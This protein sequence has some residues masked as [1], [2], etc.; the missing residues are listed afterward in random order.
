MRKS[1]FSFLFLAA[2][3]VFALL[4]PGAAQAPEPSARKPLSRSAERWVQQTLKKMT[5]EEKIGQLLMVY[6]FGGFTSQE[7]ELY[8]DWMARVEKYRVGG[9]VV[10]TRGSALGIERATVYPTAA[11]ANQLQRHAKVPLLVAADF[12]RGTNMRLVEGTSFP[13]AMGVAAT[14]NPQDAYTMGRISAIEARAAGVHW[15]FAPVADV[16]INPDNPIIN[17]RSFGEDPKLVSEFVAAFTRG[18]EENGA[19]ST[20]KH[21]PGH[22][23]TAVDSHL[24]LSVVSGDRARLDAVELPPFRAAIA[25]GA[26]TIMTGHLAVPALEPNTELPATLSSKVLTGV[27]REEMK[28]DG[29]IVTDALDMGGVTSRYPPAEVAVRSIEAG[30]DMLLV[31]PILDSAVTALKAAVASGRIS[32]KRLDESVTR[33]LRAKARLGL[34]K[35]RFVDLDRLNEQF[36]RPEFVAA[37]QDVADRGVTLLR[38]EPK[39]VPLDG[40]QPRGVM[41]LAVAGDRDPVPGELVEAEL[42]PRVDS[43]MVVRTDTGFRPAENVKLPAPETYDLAIAALF[44]RVADSKGTVGLPENQTALV[45][46]LLAGGKPVVVMSFG[47][48]YLISR[49]PNAPTWM[50]SFTT[51]DVAQRA[52]VRGLFGQTAIGGRIPV[53]LPGAFKIGD[54][55]ST[56]AVPMRLRAAGAEM[57]AKLEPARELLERA[58]A[59][60]AFPGAVLAVGHRG[61]LAVVAVGRQGYDAKWPAVAPDTLYDMASLTKPLVTATSLARLVEAGRV[62]LDSPIAR[63]LPEFAAGREIEFGT[64]RYASSPKVGQVL[65]HAGGLEELEDVELSI[66]GKEAILKY[67]MTAKLQTEPASETKYSNVGYWLLGTIIERVSGQPLETFARA[68]IF[69]PLGMRDTMFNPPKY[70]LPR[71]APTSTDHALRKRLLHGEVE[72][73]TTWRM[74]GASGAA[75][76]FSTAPDVAV[77]CQMWLNGGVYAHQRILRRSTIE[78]FSKLETL[79]GG[80]RSPAW[81]FAPAMTPVPGGLSDKSLWHTGSTGTSILMDPQN[82]LFIILLTNAVHPDGNTAKLEHVRPEIHRAVIQALLPTP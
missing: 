82:G 34:E 70:L 24:D 33:I 17:V 56:A 30:A 59:E 66:Q 62:S 20:A 42:R 48:P 31:P 50:A 78:R 53:S 14:G 10:Q 67:V 38:D 68:R 72:G 40:T 7:S 65:R 9:F 75:G 5:V 46:A 21:F 77:F 22:G 74:G 49:F 4:V 23:D 52:A 55:L 76:L 32:V 57:N 44:V 60:K 29:I 73:N 1:H 79:A 36:R 27:L 64:N 47:S 37:A 15:I 69:E 26:S 58:V 12:E 71:I 3:L 45:N 19:L 18:V 39:L 43:L 81:A 13:Q 51:Q 54:G 8:K 28:F 25:A 16:N 80:T 35:Q 6:Y 11:L 2:L 63:F 61:E 41:L